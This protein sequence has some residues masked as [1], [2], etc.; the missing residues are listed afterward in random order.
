[1][2]SRKV[3]RKAGNG[4][5]DL[6]SRSR[7]APRA[8]RPLLVCLTLLSAVW[9]S[10]PALASGPATPATRASGEEHIWQGGRLDADAGYPGRWERELSRREQMLKRN[11]GSIA[12]IVSI[13]G[14]L[15]ELE[16]EIE[17]ARLGAL[18]DGVAKDRRSNP[19]VRAHAAYTHARLLEHGGD[20][21]G[22]DAIYASQGFVS[23]WMIVGP[24]ENANGVGIAT[25]YTPESEP[26]SENQ[27]FEGK[28][29][30]EA[31]SWRYHDTADALTGAYVSF[32]EFLFPNVEVVGYATT[33]VHSDR[34]REALLSI[35]A[36]GAYRAWV[37]GKLVGENDAERTP[38]PLQDAFTVPLQKGWNRVVL[39]LAADQT[40]WGFYSR[41]S[42]LKG[43]PLGGVA[44]S[45]RPDPSKGKVDRVALATSDAGAA[46]PDPARVGARALL[47]ARAGRSD[48]GKKAGA[49]KLELAE[50]YRWVRPFDRN[51]SDDYKVAQRADELLQTAWSA[52]IASALASDQNDSRNALDRA[53]ARAQKAGATQA[54][55][56]GELLLE[57]SWRYR[58]LGLTTRARATLNRARRVAPDDAVIELSA[59]DQLSDDGFRLAALAWVEDLATRYPTSSIIA[60]ER[61]AREMDL[62][63]VRKGLG[64]LESLD[65]SRR[66]DG[67]SAEAR[68][69]AHLQLGEVEQAR[70]LA[71]ALVQASPSR[72][73]VYRELASLYEAES[74]YE[75]ALEALS[76]AVDLAPQNAN[77]HRERGELLA[78]AGKREQS[79]LAFQRSLELMPQQPVLRD[80]LATFGAQ[81][82]DDLFAIHG[83][84]LESVV[85][86][87]AKKGLPANWKGKEAG[88]LLHRI[89][90]RISSNGLGERVD[91]RIIR[92]LDDRGVR[93]Q[94][95]HAYS[96]DPAESYVE[97]RRARVMHAD[98]SIEEL[99]EVGTF[100]LAAAG[101]RMYYD[102]RQIRVGFSGLR[103]GDTLEVV[104][105]RR[106]VAA[107]NIF[108]DYYG[109]VVPLEASVPIARLEYLLEA[110]PEMKMHFNRKV[111]VAAGEG[112]E[113]ADG[114]TQ[115]RLNRAAVPAVKGEA[116]MPGWTESLE[117]LHVST[118]GDWDSVARWYWDLVEEQ[119]IVNDEIRSG[120]GQAIAELAPDAS[121]RAKVD[122]VYRHVISKTR[123]VGL[124]FGIHGYKPYRTTDI[125]NRRFGDCKDKASL[126]KVMLAEI[127]VESHLVLVRTRDQGRIGAKPASLS[128]FNHAIVYVP[129]YDLFLDGTAEWSGP[130]EL[131]AG[132]QGASVLVVEDGR[133]G[134]FM[135]IPVSR[136]EANQKRV[137]EDIVLARDGSAKVQ[138]S[139]EVHGAA[140]AGW[141][142]GFQAEEGRVDQLTRMFSRQFP[143]TT[144]SGAKF[145]RLDDVR[146]PI[147]LETTLDVPV[148]AN[149][150]SR[151]LRFRA[152]GRE[153]SLVRGLASQTQRDHE[154]VLNT[155]VS[156]RRELNYTLPSGMRVGSGPETRKVKSKFGEFKMQVEIDDAAGKASVTT[157]LRIDTWRVG[158][159][160][161]KDFREFL[162][163]IDAAL[164]QAF[165]LEARQ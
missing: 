144:V 120:V 67:A 92:I 3:N 115:Y 28:L 30:G 155:P 132:D 43:A 22:A 79:V 5:D 59:V 81:G 9:V 112:A 109:E 50:F 47:E 116:N 31:L 7:V 58:A 154:L 134:R 88:T 151:G 95:V 147:R 35:G 18:L 97:V 85:A 27:S 65:D 141:R 103:V 135:R 104:F 138:R 139:M 125:Y 80:L 162:R 53:I 20:A 145:D 129:K 42:D 118:Y 56:L 25:A 114:L 148:W 11:R 142:S 153:S 74:R 60:R 84:Q 15:G 8:R 12:A 29:S 164:G 49:A 32:D 131:P 70:K 146:E 143:G 62:G 26:Y 72:P 90:Q 71:E 44:V 161:Y 19:F 61:A 73:R 89:V 111:K 96:F 140:A 54:P 76:V 127:G 158:P 108:D 75:D 4:T 121:E 165:E 17:S 51:E 149:V 2:R 160:E 6:E 117:Y 78:R 119:L 113:S 23:E 36:G 68:I 124:E 86:E 13:V 46:K 37:G 83:A 38:D 93:S 156:E 55:L 123:Y 133:G 1:M 82:G 14:L 69:R 10:E 137:R 107:E 159:G 63:R 94:S 16:G 34:Q 64:R 40:M 98:G 48:R 66:A 99:G 101:Y 24:F 110:P 39:K 150:D 87:A 106:D 105:V 163:Q 152:T 102:Q 21:K 128:A 136:A 52:W 126:L 45:A 130:D 157:D 41:I 91:Q 122:A 57:L 100:S 33:W 77:Y